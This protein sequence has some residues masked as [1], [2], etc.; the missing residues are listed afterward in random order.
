MLLLLIYFHFKWKT[1]G[2]TSLF[3]KNQIRKHTFFGKVYAKSFGH[4]TRGMSCPSLI[5]LVVLTSKLSLLVIMWVW[6]NTVLTC[7]FKQS[8]QIL[9]STENSVFILRTLLKY[10]YTGIPLEVMDT[11]VMSRCSHHPQ[12]LLVCHS[13]EGKEPQLSGIHLFCPVGALRSP[14]QQS[15]CR[16]QLTVDLYVVGHRWW[17]TDRRRFQGLSFLERQF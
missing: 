4:F 8:I 2:V 11:C 9:F 13:D 15:P 1:D 12:V 5:Q 14:P 16:C 6:R 17:L 10:S 7:R 3:L